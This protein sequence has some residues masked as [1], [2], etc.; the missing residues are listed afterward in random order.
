MHTAVYGPADRY[1]RGQELALLPSG[2]L[3]WGE[4]VWVVFWP[5]YVA[6]INPLPLPWTWC[7]CWVVIP[8][9]L[10]LTG[11]LA[12][13]VFPVTPPLLLALQQPAGQDTSAYVALTASGSRES[14]IRGQLAGAAGSC[15][16]D[17]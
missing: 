1:S 6:A 11:A 14:N 15:A 12:Q 4:G 5:C 16:W 17:G 2:A 9:F 13:F 10:C 3:G 8:E 7:G